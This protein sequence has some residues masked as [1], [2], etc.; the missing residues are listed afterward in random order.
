MY[1]NYRI[2]FS[3]PKLSPSRDPSYK[4]DLIVLDC[5]GREKIRL[6]FEKNTYS[7]TSLKIIVTKQE[8]LRKALRQSPQSTKSGAKLTTMLPAKTLV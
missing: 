4:T 6:T 5:F 7:I 3:H 8:I 1:F 2:E